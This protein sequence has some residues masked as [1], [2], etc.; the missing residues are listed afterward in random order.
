MNSKRSVV[1]T[2]GVFD[3]VHAGHRYLISTAKKI[4]QQSDS[5]LVA[6]SFDPHPVSVLRPDE[7]L[8]LITLPEFRAT[9]L[10][11]AGAQRVEFINF[12]QKVAQMSPD[13]FIETIVLDELN[14]ST[15]VVGENFRFGV[16]ASG[17]VTT[18][19]TLAN[20]FGF[21]LEVVKLVGDQQTWSS[22]RVRNN[23]LT[24]DVKAAREILGR[25]HRLTGKVVHGDHRGR[26]LGYPT[27]N[28]EV[29][30]N[31]IIPAD[32]VYSALV[33][34]N[35]E[36]LPAAVSIGTNPTF[37]DVASRRVEAY[38]LDRTD[39]DLYEQEISVDFL[40]FVRS[41]DKF[42]DVESLLVQM[43][44]DVENTRLQISDFLDSPSH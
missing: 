20:K 16:N 7:F 23:L 36:V 9:L 27:A 32:G 24:G 21:A 18:L 6:A 41:M 26:E 40:D 4:A 38:V 10:K 30:G 34:T 42:S 43:A 1:V 15:I 19:T 14:A 33:Y 39:L 25:P 37:D 28:L 8:G 29:F 2:V 12:D 44:L 3:G 13:E 11:Q 35:S 31:L 17:D 22:T 5:L